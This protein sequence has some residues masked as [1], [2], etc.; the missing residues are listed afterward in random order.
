M[1]RVVGL[2]RFVDDDAGVVSVFDRVVFEVEGNY[3][4]RLLVKRVAFSIP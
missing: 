3:K 4:H 1:V 2:G